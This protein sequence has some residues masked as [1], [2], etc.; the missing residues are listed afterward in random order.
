ME[1]ISVPSAVYKPY[2]IS[3]QIPYSPTHMTINQQ[4]NRPTDD[5]QE[6][7]YQSLHQVHQGALD[8]SLYDLIHTVNIHWD[9]HSLDNFD[10]FALLQCL[11]RHL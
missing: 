6:K 7:I 3:R 2:A 9:F 4:Q 10:I 5:Q 11:G 1:S 8:A